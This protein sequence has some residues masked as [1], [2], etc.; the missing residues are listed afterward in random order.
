MPLASLVR[1]R[2]VTAMALGLGDAD[3]AAIAR[4]SY[5]NAGLR[6]GAKE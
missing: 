1:D 3:W 6:K 4:F 2:F 5:E